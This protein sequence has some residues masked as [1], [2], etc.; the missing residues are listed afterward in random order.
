MP[1]VS[2]A[3]RWINVAGIALAVALF[4]WEKAARQRGVAV[5]DSSN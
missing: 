5:G 3:G 1:G 4:V 2:G